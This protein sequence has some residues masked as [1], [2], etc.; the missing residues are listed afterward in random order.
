MSRAACLGAACVV[1]VSG[2]PAQRHLARLTAHRVGGVTLSRV[3]F[4]SPTRA[5]RNVHGVELVVSSRGKDTV[6]SEWEQQ[7]YVGAYL[8]LMAR[9][10]KAAV[11][12]VATAHTEGA[13][14]QAS[15]FLRPYEVFGSN[16][17][18]SKVALFRQRLVAAATRANARVIELRTSAMPARAIAL[19]V[20]VSDPAVFL[21]H[22]AK[23]LLSLLNFPS[24]PLLGY[25]LGAVDSSGQLFWAT[26]Q[27]PGT[28]ATYAIRSLDSCNPV[29]HSEPSLF[30][31]PPCPAN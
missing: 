20:R 10:P 6:R 17:S 31:P 30:Q 21:K 1:I 9:W 12:A 7:L 8:G 5:L 19:T 25:Y 11:A 15:T 27:L 13:V 18:S 24:I 16:P 26:S 29:A 22:R 28:G 14:E 3:V 4:R 2:T 23:S